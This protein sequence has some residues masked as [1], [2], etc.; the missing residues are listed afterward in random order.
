MRGG[1]ESCEY[2]RY[3]GYTFGISRNESAARK[4][5]G[6]HGLRRWDMESMGQGE[7]KVVGWG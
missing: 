3:V 1:V 6:Q 7:E 5:F 4:S 2:T